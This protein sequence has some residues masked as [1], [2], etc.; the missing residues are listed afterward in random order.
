MLA[1]LL[2]GAILLSPWRHLA[3]VQRDVAVVGASTIRLTRYLGAIGIDL[4][5]FLVGLLVSSGAIRRVGSRVALISGTAV[6]AALAL[7]PVSAA[8]FA[9]PRWHLAGGSLTPILIMAA[10]LMVNGFPVVARIL[11]ER[12]LLAGDLGATVLRA[13]S[14]LV[15]LPFLIVVAVEHRFRSAGSDA[16]YVLWWTVALAVAVGLTVLWPR[17]RPVFARIVV[18]DATVLALALVAVLIGAWL[19]TRVLG[20]GLVGSFVVGVALSGSARASDVVDR[21]LGRVVPT[22]LV[23]VYFAAAGARIQPRALDAGVLAAAVLFTVLL[24][25]VGA[26]GGLASLRAEGIGA[27]EART[28]AALLTCRGLM[29]LALASGMADDRLI[30]TRLAMVFFLGALL[31]TL[32]TG[33]LLHW[34]DRD[35]R[36]Q[37]G[38]VGVVST[39]PG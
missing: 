1:G 26:L 9:A 19:S 38:E 34:A 4:Y 25:A 12:D 30:G 16:L 36:R 32:M 23:P 27:A 11:Q 39:T 20:T 37:P 22:I 33:P 3:G 28:I 35:G 14:V 24:T 15:T 10:A 2:V 5:M 7:A 29:L 21:S 13:S 6:L 8:V 17:V 31:T 18:S